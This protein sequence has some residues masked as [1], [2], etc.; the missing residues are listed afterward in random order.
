[1]PHGAAATQAAEEG[2]QNV[3]TSRQVAR[4]SAGLRKLGKPNDNE[5]SRG[6]M[7]EGLEQPL[8]Q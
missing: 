2:I 8:L 6:S 3:P 4:F 7:K 5:S 1:M